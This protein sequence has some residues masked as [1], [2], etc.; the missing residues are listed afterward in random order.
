[1]FGLIS[2]VMVFEKNELLLLLLLNLFLKVID[3][4]MVIIL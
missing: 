2:D 1:M 4:K 3:I